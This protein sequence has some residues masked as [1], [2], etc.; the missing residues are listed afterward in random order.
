[1]ALT[2]TWLK[3]HKDAEVGIEGF[4][5][6][7][8]DR[9]R[10]KKGTR[11][12]L[13]GG[14]AA[15]VNNDIANKMEVALDYSNG[16]VEV[17]GLYSRADNLFLA[18]VYRQPDDPTGGN[19][20]T[21]AE[22]KP[23]VTK[24]SNILSE[25]ENPAPNV[26]ICGD[27]N[28]PHVSWPEAKNMPGA[29]PQEREMLECLS[30]FLDE[31]FLKQH[32]STPTHIAG[33]TLDLVFS[34][35]DYLLHSYDCLKPLRSVSHHFVIESYTA[36]NSNIG[37]IEEDKPEYLSHL[38]KLNFFSNDIEWD[39]MN[40]EF[41]TYDWK[42]AI[43]NLQPDEMLIKIMQVI[44]EVCNKYVPL[45]KSLYKNGKSKIPRDRRILM[46][47]RRKITLKLKSASTKEKKEKLERKLINIEIALQ[48]SNQNAKS[49]HEQKAINA[50]K[51][52]PKYF[53]SYAKKFSK[54]K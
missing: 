5:I 23:A 48:K 15:Y 11:G 29:S 1:M 47:K 10:K 27:F 4:K 6:F 40:E 41:E 39:K 30:G 16:V 49:Q 28:L 3:N 53:F 50:I 52:N 54:T 33:N 42:H 8:A 19:R 20:S 25:L 17:L 24:L 35:N 18:V 22:F 36:F 9:K 31:H 43:S 34:N 7:R 13:S 21:I 32:I 12:R 46:R 38:D 14:V 37:E 45:R 51:S 26:I 44:L 2:E